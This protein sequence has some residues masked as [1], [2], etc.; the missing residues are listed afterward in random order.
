ME[1]QPTLHIQ[2]CT[3]QH[4]DRY[5][6]RQN[7]LAS[8]PYGPSPLWKREETA[9]KRGKRRLESTFSCYKINNI[10]E[11]FG[12]LVVFIYFCNVAI[13]IPMSN[14][15][16]TNKDKFLSD[17]INGILPKTNAVI[18][19]G[20]EAKYNVESVELVFNHR[21]KRHDLSLIESVV[22]ENKE[23][24]IERWRSYFNK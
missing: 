11:Q 16:I 7:P 8:L 2:M 20:C 17:I 22:L 10:P 1:G 23:I 24:I 6:T 21:F 9:R 18:G 3:S 4:T 19:D 15:F 12:S 5:L 14:S 13:M